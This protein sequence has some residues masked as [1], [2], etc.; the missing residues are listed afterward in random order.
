MTKLAAI[1]LTLCVLACGKDKSGDAERVPQTPPAVALGGVQACPP[2][3]VTLDG[4]PIAGLGHGKGVTLMNAGYTTHM[5][6]L[7][8]H[9]K[10]TCEDTL[11]LRHTQEEG[12][13]N[14]RAWHGAAPGVGIDAFTQVEGKIT[15]DRTPEKV[16]DDLDIC[17]REP[18]SFTPNA[19]TYSGKKVAIVGKFSGVFC[20]VNKT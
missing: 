2:L 13:I 15:L 18:I 8:N 5:V 7:Y 20:G 11:A 3:S 4:A 9:D 1:G 16:G 14:V 10:T 12:E 6:Q 17:V 19:G